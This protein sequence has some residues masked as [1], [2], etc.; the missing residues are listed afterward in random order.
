MAGMPGEGCPWVVVRS[1]RTQGSVAQAGCSAG[2]GR[3]GKSGVLRFSFWINAELVHGGLCTPITD[4]RGQTLGLTPSLPN[5]CYFPLTFAHVS[6]SPTV[7]LNTGRPGLE[8]L[9]RQK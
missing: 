3:E 8:S 9:S 1:W 4:S 6:R 2:I 5:P 7:R